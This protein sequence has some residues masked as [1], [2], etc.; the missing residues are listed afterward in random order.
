MNDAV[1]N[2]DFPTPGSFIQE[3][4]DARGWSQSDLAYILGVSVQSI[5]PVIVGR[6]GISTEMARSLGNAFDVPAELF[7]NL[8][9]AYDL[10]KTKEPDPGIAKRAR[11]QDH[12]PLRE[13]I[14]RGWLEDTK[15]D[16]LLDAQ[17][18]RFFRVKSV[19]EIPYL[20]HAAKKSRY[21]EKEIPPAQ[22][23]WLFRVHQIAREIAAPKYSKTLLEKSLDSLRA[24]TSAPEEIR[25][26][27][28]ILASCGVRFIVVEAMPQA[29][30]DGVC[31]WIDS[32]SPVIGMS[33]RFDRIDNFWF[34]LRHEIEHVIQR[35]GIDG[36]ILDD[37]EGDRAGLGKDL[38]EEERVA[39]RAASEFCAP[40]NDL[41]SFLARKHPYLSEKD[42]LGFAAKHQIHPGIV[43]GQIHA[44]TENYKLLRKH[45]VKIRQFIANYAP[46][47]GWGDVFPVEI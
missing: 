45:L 2:S 11:L 8:Q 24:L 39:N 12:F 6:R 15:D 43:I 36:E 5:N 27:P 44:K 10:S 47:D 23:A 37:L 26:V 14:K 22:L 13:M 34:V 46:T 19:N 28:Q 25:K 31:F 30:I 18:I 7:S 9:T 3:E 41:D 21:E 42:I 35:H 32:H 29:K 20:S 4:L 38:P 1:I 17:L 40:M 16:S 33:I